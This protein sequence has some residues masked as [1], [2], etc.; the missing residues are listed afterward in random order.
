MLLT[1]KITDKHNKI[2]LIKRTIFNLY[3]LAITI[4][5]YILY[6]IINIFYNLLPF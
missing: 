2:F 4:N 3:Y 6:N 1:N 5:V